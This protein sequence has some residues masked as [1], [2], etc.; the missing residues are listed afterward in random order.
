[1]R[2]GVLPSSFLP[3]YVLTI[4]NTDDLFESALKNF[5]RLQIPADPGLWDKSQAHGEKLISAEKKLLKGASKP[6]IDAKSRINLIRAHNTL[7]DEIM[8][9]ADYDNFVISAVKLTTL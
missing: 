1:M 6:N 4:H 2:S 8:L 9:A 3:W 7:C 5:P